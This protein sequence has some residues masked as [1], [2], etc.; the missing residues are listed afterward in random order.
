MSPCGTSLCFRGSNDRVAPTLISMV[1]AR[2]LLSDGALSY[3][4]SI[5][6]TSVSETS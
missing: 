3:L 5:I 6:D 1:E 2:V 4:A